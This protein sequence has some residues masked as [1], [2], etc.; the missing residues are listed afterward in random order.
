MVD[1]QQ[2]KP[3]AAA[4]RITDEE[5][6]IDG[7]EDLRRSLF[8]L[9]AMRQRGLID[10]ATWSERRRALLAAAAEAPATNHGTGGGNRDGG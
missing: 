1:R 6:G 7:S 8:A 4:S 3:P 10:E 5:S 2:P 9:D